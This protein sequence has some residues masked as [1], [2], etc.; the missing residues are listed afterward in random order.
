MEGIKSDSVYHES[1][2]SKQARVEREVTNLYNELIKTPEI[3]E[4][5]TLLD[6]LPKHL[7]YHNKEHTLDVL[8]E[9]ILFA[10]ADD[11]SRDTIDEQAIAAAWHDVGYLERDKD[12][13]PVAVELFEKSSA[14]QKLSEDK[15]RE[16]AA[17][18]LDTAMVTKE[19]KPVFLQECSDYGYILDGDVSNFGRKDFFE[20]GEK[21]A[22]ELGVD[23]SNPQAKAGFYKFT[24][25][26]LRN[27]EW[28]TGSA[29]E[30]RQHQK[31]ENIFELEERC[32]DLK[33]M[34]YQQDSDE[35]I[36][37]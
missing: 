31:E 7:R 12:N 3:R 16:V 23:F 28:K 26:L 11:A 37:A 29:R 17:N 22:E 19:G 25:E 9:T 20:K 33:D 15:R 27:H 21:L 35:A 1:P 18:I 30:L 32:F 8:H 6:G 2:E 36:A 14:Y 13:E 5:L 34:S 24:L 10:V 4:A